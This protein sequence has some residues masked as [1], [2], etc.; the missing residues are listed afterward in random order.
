MTLILPAICWPR[1]K[2]LRIVV[3]QR[4][5][6]QIRR[7]HLTPRSIESLTHPQT[8]SKPNWH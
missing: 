8:T 5:D 3:A 7:R 1:G 2:V 4:D 6:V